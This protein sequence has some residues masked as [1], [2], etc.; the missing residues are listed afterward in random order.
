MIRSDGNDQMNSVWRG[1]CKA[2]NDR[3]E[4]FGFV[5]ADFLDKSEQL[6]EL[7]QQ[8]ANLA[9]R[10]ESQILRNPRERSTA[11]IELLPHGPDLF[12]R[13]PG[14]ASMLDARDRLCQI[15]QGRTAGAHRSGLPLP[16]FP[17]ALAI[18]LSK[19]AGANERRF[20]AARSAMNDDDLGRR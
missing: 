13:G 17:G 5:R 2:A 1:V 7:V 9:F 11:D 3:S 18:Q 19:N 14:A 12:N 4:H 16:S 15:P 10:A 8:D 6:L 20:A